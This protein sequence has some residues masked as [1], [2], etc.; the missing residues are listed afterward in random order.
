MGKRESELRNGSSN[1][2]KWRGVTVKAVKSD[3]GSTD[4]LRIT[5]I[6]WQNT[7]LTGAIPDELGALSALTKL[8]L[9]GNQLTGEKRAREV[10][11]SKVPQP[12]TSL[13]ELR[14]DHS[15]LDSFPCLLDRALPRRQ[16]SLRPHPLVPRVPHEPRH[17]LFAYE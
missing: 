13:L 11:T 12:A 14:R 17:A 6:L 7:A 5:A 10:A 1:V 4:K 8:D 3:R 9:S 16:P 15:L 2:S